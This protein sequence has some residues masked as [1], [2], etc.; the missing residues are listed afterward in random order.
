MKFIIATIIVLLFSINTLLAQIGLRFD[1][2][3]DYVSMTMPILNN[4]TV[5]F[6]IK[7]NGTDGSYDRIVSTAEDAFE[8]A[9]NGAGDISYYLGGW[10]SAT[11]I[12]TGVWTHLAFVRSGNIL[13]I[14]RNG[15]SV[16]SASRTSIAIPISW[17]IGR[18][19]NG[20]GEHA[21]ASIDEF[22]VWNIARTQI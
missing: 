21:N 22:R 1:G 7:N 5:E 13:T 17:N 14:Y 19:V 10:V 16:Y 15:S 11:S 4:F 9:K 3:N 12:D 20:G 2:S 18:R 8:I 6:W